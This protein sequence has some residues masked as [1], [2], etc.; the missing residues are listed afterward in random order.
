MLAA[1][2]NG[3]SET[4]G[5]TVEATKFGVAHYRQED[6]LIRVDL[7]NDLE[8]ALRKISDGYVL[9]LVQCLRANG[10]DHAKEHSPSGPQP[11]RVVPRRVMEPRWPL[12]A[13]SMNLCPW[14]RWVEG[15]VSSDA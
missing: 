10:F 6:V 1:P 9:S 7:I 14:F 11:R 4:T 8:I 3:A 2:S 12:L 13:F 5:T 15:L